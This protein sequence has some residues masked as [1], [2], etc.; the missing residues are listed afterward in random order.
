MDGMNIGTDH[1]FKSLRCSVFSVSDQE[2]SQS[3]LVGDTVDVATTIDTRRPTEEAQS[4]FDF[5]DLF[6]TG[7]YTAM[8]RMACSDSILM[9]VSW[10]I[11]LRM[12]GVMVFLNEFPFVTHSVYK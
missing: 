8:C 5:K 2:T 4:T 1:I 11:A 3:V 7:Y 12:V 9:T 6:P 10:I